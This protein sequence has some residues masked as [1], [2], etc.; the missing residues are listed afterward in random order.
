[1][2][3][4]VRIVGNTGISGL[5][6]EWVG[7]GFVMEAEKLPNGNV[8]L[9][10]TQ[11]VEIAFASTNPEGT[12]LEN[13]KFDT[14]KI[15]GRAFRRAVGKVSHMARKVTLSDDVNAWECFNDRGRL[16]SWPL[17]VILIKYGELVLAYG[18]NIIPDNSFDMT[19]RYIRSRALIEETIKKVGE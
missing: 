10:P 19:D 3:K 9:R 8:I 17:K 16:I 12:K 4:T 1:M 7:E 2:K 14:Y 5:P 13:V 6:P 15:D 11:T 18:F